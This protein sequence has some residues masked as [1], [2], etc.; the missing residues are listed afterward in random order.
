MHRIAKALAPT[1]LLLL[2]VA[3]AGTA[4]AQSL[5]V[6]AAAVGRGA[7][8][9]GSG[10][11]F[12][13]AVAGVR[14]GATTVGAG[15]AV[16]LFG[17]DPATVMQLDLALAE[18]RV[19][20]P[21]GNVI[22]EAAGALRT[23]GDAQA[24]VTVRGTI[25][26]VAARLD[27][28]AFTA[29]PARFAPTAVA[30]DARPSFGTSGAGGRLGLTARF[31]RDLILDVA[32]EL[33]LT[34]TGTSARLDARLR[35]LRTFGDQELR[36]YL[37]AAGTPR[38]DAWH[39]ALG[40]GVVWP[41]GR[42]PDVEAALSIGVSSAPGS[43]AVALAPGARVSLAENLAGGLRLDV[44][45]GYEGYRVDV[46]PLRASAGLDIPLADGTLRLESALAAL[47]PT[48]PVAAVLATS[49]S[50]PVT[51]R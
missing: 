6:S 5:S 1:L 44:V 9:P 2:L 10:A 17:A 23:D 15:L 36:V 37:H 14:V 48:R 34:A 11:A 47:D 27:L 26:P 49:W 50:M 43:A 32:P 19:F 21:L 22:V 29:D 25:G 24:S 4:A 12:S 28:A 40:V 20:G 39:T 30:S 13:V 35:R 41:R 45:A 38:F 7:A 33:Y 42:A 31:G 51:L 16:R 8:A 18:N 46:H 3:P